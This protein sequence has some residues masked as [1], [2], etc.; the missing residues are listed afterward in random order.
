VRNQKKI[1]KLLINSV[2]KKKYSK[3]CNYFK[4]GSSALQFMQ[5]LGLKGKSLYQKSEQ[6]KLKLMQEYQ[7]RQT[8]ESKSYVKRRG[9]AE[10]P[11]HEK[12]MLVHRKTRDEFRT[13]IGSVAYKSQSPYRARPKYTAHHG[14]KT[15]KNLNS[16]GSTALGQ[17]KAK[18]KK[19]M[20][21]SS[22]NFKG[23]EKKIE[24]PSSDSELLITQ[25]NQS[26]TIL[27]KIDPY[28]HRSKV[29]HVSVK[30]KKKR[31]EA[32]HKLKHY[33]KKAKNQKSSLGD[34]ENTKVKSKKA[35]G[36]Q[37]KLVK[38]MAVKRDF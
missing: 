6:R 10:N 38:M 18:G 12:T 17:G 14:H 29:E 36:K 1:K 2:F 35:K 28:L 26:P 9:D 33:H 22:S 3:N 15:Y 37:K 27:P 8:Y 11:R 23:F 19:K 5:G 7:Q 20:V 13:E 30:S 25:S 4:N 34:Y 32:A 21:S 24:L 31:Y 16:K